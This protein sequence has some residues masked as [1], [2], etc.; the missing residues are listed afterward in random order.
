MVV[1]YTLQK[2]SPSSICGRVGDVI[3][4]TFDLLLMILCFWKPSTYNPNLIE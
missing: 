4:G 2:S 1:P 3:R